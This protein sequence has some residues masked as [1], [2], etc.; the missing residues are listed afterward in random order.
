MFY[1][2]F[3]IKFFELNI[4]LPLTPPLCAA[5]KLTDCHQIMKCVF[6][7]LIVIVTVFCL[8]IVIVIV[9]CLFIVIVIVFLFMDCYWYCFLFIDC[10]CHCFLFIYCYCYCYCFLFIYLDSN[11]DSSWSINMKQKAKCLKHWTICLIWNLI[12]K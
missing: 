9:F 6:C 11:M 8:W 5:M 7:L 10:Y 3:L 1:C 4:L 12:R 2:L